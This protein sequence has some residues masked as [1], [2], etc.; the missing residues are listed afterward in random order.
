LAEELLFGKL[1]SGGVVNVGRDKAGKLTF[2]FSD[3]TQKSSGKTD[4]KV[5]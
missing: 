2:K 5:N 3:G 4:E 1:T